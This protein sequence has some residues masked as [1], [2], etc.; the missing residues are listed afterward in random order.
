[1]N[2]QW[3]KASVTKS[4]AAGSCASSA[5][6]SFDGSTTTASNSTDG[7]PSSFCLAGHSV[8]SAAFTP[9]I[10]GAT[11]S[12]SARSSSAAALAARAAA[13]R[14]D[15]VGDEHADLAAGEAR[16][17]VL[18]DAQRRRRREVRARLPARRGSGVGQLLQPQAV[19]HVPRQVLVRC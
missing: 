11:S 12:S 4:L 19:G 13:R 10:F 6:P 16:R 2:L 7:P 3:A 17:A 5:A 8:P 1:M 18:E 15:A 14:V 9:P